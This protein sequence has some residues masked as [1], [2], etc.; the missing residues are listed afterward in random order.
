MA[1]TKEK[2]KKKKVTLRT[3]NKETKFRFL[4][5]ITKKKAETDFL[6][7]KTEE[8]SNELVQEQ[9]FTSQLRSA[10]SSF[11]SSQSSSTKTTNLKK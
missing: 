5:V 2:E 1:I 11:T 7:H 3:K 10:D 9:T 4:I 6:M 8:P